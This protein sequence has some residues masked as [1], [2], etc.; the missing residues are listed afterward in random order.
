MMSLNLSWVEF[1]F[2]DVID[3]LRRI[4]VSNFDSRFVA[5]WNLVRS[6][7]MFFWGTEQVIFGW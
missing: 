2:V 6:V 5:P 1:H 3:G 4:V 7:C